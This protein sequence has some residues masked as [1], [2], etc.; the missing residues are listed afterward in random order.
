MSALCALNL[1]HCGQLGEEGG[2]FLHGNTAVFRFAPEIPIS[3]LA[4]GS[5]FPDE[6]PQG[7]YLL[8]VD[9]TD[10]AHCNPDLDWSRYLPSTVLLSRNEHDRYAFLLLFTTRH[11]YYTLSEFSIS[12]SNSSPLGACASFP[13]FSYETCTEPS[14][15]LAHKHHLKRPI[16]PQCCT[17]H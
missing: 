7:R 9:G 5:R 6:K 13:T 16:I 2:L 15:C 3:I 4:S 10:E 11:Q 14:L 17:T 1:R 8:L 12:Y